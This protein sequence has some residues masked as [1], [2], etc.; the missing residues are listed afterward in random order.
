MSKITSQ[1]PFRLFDHN[2]D[3]QKNFRQ[4]AG[5]EKRAVSTLLN[6]LFISLFL[7]RMESVVGFMP[8][9]SLP[10]EPLANTLDN[11]SILVTY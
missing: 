10:A 8:A 11:S 7:F 9:I 5:K 2:D 4:Q 1:K 6:V 3:R